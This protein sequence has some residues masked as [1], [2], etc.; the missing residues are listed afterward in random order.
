MPLG[1]LNE[2]AIKLFIS[3]A[4][5]EMMIEDTGLGYPRTKDLVVSKQWT[6]EQKEKLYAQIAERVKTECG[7]DDLHRRKW[8]RRLELRDG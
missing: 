5:E 4:L 2:I 3:T 7:V 6:K 1:Y 8:R